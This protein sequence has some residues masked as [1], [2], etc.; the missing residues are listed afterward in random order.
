MR[1][2]VSIKQ[3]LHGRGGIHQLRRLRIKE[4]FENTEILIIFRLFGAVNGTSGRT[5]GR[6]ESLYKY[7]I[8]IMRKRETTR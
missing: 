3:E 2:S 5:I 6:N 1:V 7:Q 8:E 4:P